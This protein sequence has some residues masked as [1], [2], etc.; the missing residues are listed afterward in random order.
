MVFWD[1][2]HGTSGKEPVCQCRRHKRYGFDPLV[3]KIP[4]GRAWQSTAVF[5]P[6]ESHG[7][8]ILAGY[9]PQGCKVGS[10]RVGHDWATELNWNELKRLGVHTHGPRNCIYG[11]GGICIIVTCP[12]KMLLLLTWKWLSQLHCSNFVPTLPSVL[13]RPH[14]H[15]LMLIIYL[16][17]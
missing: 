7:Q 17:E 10:Q 6:K 1:F 5:L 12:E 14:S 11:G 2:P 3:R 16:V 15:N 8:R 13:E 9:S 4:Q